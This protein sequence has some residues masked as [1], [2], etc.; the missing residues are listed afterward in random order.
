MK[1]W[2]IGKSLSTCTN[3]FKYCKYKYMLV[4]AHCISELNCSAER[5]PVPG[6]A[7]A[8]DVVQRALMK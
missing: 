3:R 8:V 4:Y 5:A 6:H 1:N 2:Y 7:A